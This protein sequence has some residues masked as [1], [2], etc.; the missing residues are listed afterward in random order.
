MGRLAM[1]W[2][3]MFRETFMPGIRSSYASCLHM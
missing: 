1:V 2:L 3:Y